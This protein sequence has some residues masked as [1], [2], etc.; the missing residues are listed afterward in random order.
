MTLKRKH[1]QSV[2]TWWTFFSFFLWKKSTTQMLMNNQT[3]ELLKW[4]KTANDVII[5]LKLLIQS[6]LPIKNKLV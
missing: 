3:F 2:N 5:V 1:G 6:K 4:A